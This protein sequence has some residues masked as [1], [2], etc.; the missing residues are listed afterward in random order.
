[1][2]LKSN[3]ISIIRKG[4][5]TKDHKITYNIV[6]RL[7]YQRGPKSK[8]VL[9][10]PTTSAPPLIELRFSPYIFIIRL[11][12][13]WLLW[14]SAE[15]N[16]PLN[17][18]WSIASPKTMKNREAHRS[19]HSDWTVWCVQIIFRCSAVHRCHQHWKN[20]WMERVTRRESQHKIFFA[21][22]FQEKINRN[23]FPRHFCNECY[24]GLFKTFTPPREEERKILGPNWWVPVKVHLKRKRFGKFGC[25]KP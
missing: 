8:A 7:I 4:K 10:A 13:S 19:L 11:L 25:Q 14:T 15:R 21:T 20:N 6:G 5:T 2:T 16:I 12:T 1:M 24:I 23:M 3:I 17:L 9:K 18:H 22:P